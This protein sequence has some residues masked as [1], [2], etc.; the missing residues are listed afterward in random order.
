MQVTTLV[1]P[2][3]LDR[4]RAAKKK[5]EFV[6]VLALAP[7]PVATPTTLEVRAHTAARKQTA[8]CYNRLYHFI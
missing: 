1:L 6:N 5:D 3:G 4:L 2:E 8:P 7:D